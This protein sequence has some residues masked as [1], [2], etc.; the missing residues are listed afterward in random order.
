[1]VGSADGKRRR[2]FAFT[3]NAVRQLRKDLVTT[4][5]TNDDHVQKSNSVGSSSCIYKTTTTENEVSNFDSTDEDGQSLVYPRRLSDSYREIANRHLNKLFPAQRQPVLD[6]LEGRLQAEQKGMKP[7]YDEISFIISL[8]KLTKQGKFQPNLGI[9]VR[10]S[11][12]EREAMR[13]RARTAAAATVSDES[14]E[15]REKRRAN[16]QARLSSMRR[17]LGKSHHQKSTLT[18]DA[19][20]NPS[21]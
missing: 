9:K 3:R 11:R 17:A 8:C 13:Q 15:Q 6:E 2:F 16:G 12:I 7:V 5:Q 21:E 20:E 19:S 10:D 18:A 14:E 4:Q 1:M